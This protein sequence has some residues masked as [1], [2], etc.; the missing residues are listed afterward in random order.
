MSSANGGLV[1]L[2]E[3]V[4]TLPPSEKKIARYI[5]NHPQEAISLTA[6]ELGKRS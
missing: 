3:M 2:N 4:N 5:L 1:M 6:V